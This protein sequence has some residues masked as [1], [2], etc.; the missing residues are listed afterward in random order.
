MVTVPL[1]SVARVAG[2]AGDSTEDDPMTMLR[3]Q[4][5]EIHEAALAAEVKIGPDALGEYVFGVFWIDG[6]RARPRRMFK[7]ASYRTPADVL[8]AIRRGLYWED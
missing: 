4:L 8:T 6:R 7:T 3:P 5:P 1:H 2:R